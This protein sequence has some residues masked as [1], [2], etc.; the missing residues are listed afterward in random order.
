MKTITLACK[1]F[2]GINFQYSVSFFPAENEYER[3][4]FPSR[5]DFPKQSR[6]FIGCVYAEVNQQIQCFAYVKCFSG[7]IFHRY[8]KF[9]TLDPFYPKKKPSK[10]IYY[11]VRGVYNTCLHFLTFFSNRR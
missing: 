4:V 5:P 1:K 2:P 9:Q 6:L 11:H 8:V 10:E 7:V 3:H